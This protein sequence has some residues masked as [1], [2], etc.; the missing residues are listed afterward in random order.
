MIPWRRCIRLDAEIPS[1]KI[2]YLELELLCDEARN[3]LHHPLTREFAANV[4]VTVA[5]ITN[6]AMSAAL[7]LAVEF[8]EREV[9]QQWRK[10]IGPWDCGKGSTCQWRLDPLRGANVGGVT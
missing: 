9:T 1:T 2:V 8:I 5:R 7:Q 10:R 3:A 4:D 6:K